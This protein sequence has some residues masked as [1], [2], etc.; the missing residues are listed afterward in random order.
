M[1]TA[2]TF[3]STGFSV[4]AKLVT[5][6]ALACLTGWAAWLGLRE[7]LE[8]AERT[9]AAMFFALAA[10][11]AALSA[12]T[13]GSLS[14]HRAQARSLQA[15]TERM[16][17]FHVVM[18]Q[19]NRL[20]LRRPEPA[21]L[22]SEVCEVCVAAGHTEL[23]VID[24]VGG[25]T[26]TRVAAAFAAPP[27]NGNAISP[28]KIHD[29]PALRQH[30]MQLAVESGMPVVSNDVCNDGR[31]LNW[32]ELCLQSNVNALAAIPLKR[33]AEPAGILMLCSSKTEFFVERLVPLLAEMGADLSFAL[34]NSDREHERRDALTDTARSHQLFQTLF[35]TAPVP[36]AIVS[37][38]DHKVMKANTLWCL[39]AGV[40]PHALLESSFEGPACGLDLADRKSFYERLNAIQSV[41]G[42]QTHFTSSSGERHD[43]LVHAHRVDYLGEKSFLVAATDVSELK[44]AQVADTARAVADDANRAKTDFLARMSHELRTPLNAMLGFAQLLSSD[45]HPEL[46]PTQSEQVRLM[47]KA[48]WHLLSLVDD[49]MDISGIE[50]GRVQV[51]CAPHDI[52]V[53]L[54]EAIA[55]CQPL[56]RTKRVHLHKRVPFDPEV[57]AMIDPGRLRQVLF[58]LLSNACKYNRQGGDVR[59]DMR[60]VGR[61]VVLEVTDNGIGMTAEQMTHLFE[62]FNRLGRHEQ[63]T[64]GTGI[65]LTLSRHL[66]ELMK[67]R[68]EVESS[69]AS[70]TRVRVVLPACELLPRKTRAASSLPRSKLKS[71]SSSVLYIEDNE[72]D[73]TVVEQMML[74]C[75]GVTLMQAENGTDGLAFALLKQPDLILLGMQLPD[76]S[77]FD[78]LAALRAEPRTRGL[79]VVALS[80]SVM[81]EDVERAMAL[82]ALDY[83]TKPLEMDALLEGVTAILQLRPAEVDGAKGADDE[84]TEQPLPHRGAKWARR[85]SVPADSQVLAQ[86][87]DW[88]DAL[89][90]RAR[91]VHLP[92]KFPRIA[93]EVARLWRDTAELDLYFKD[94]EFST[95][96]DR[97][98]FPPI[99]KEE[100]LAMHLHSLRTRHALPP[101]RAHQ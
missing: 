43:V 62:P 30:L 71:G 52:S 98:G 47:T 13:W 60:S 44:A 14:R 90:A 23:A 58:N 76:M 67:G 80:A 75:K 74:R 88:L 66:V 72:V 101:S 25:K 2:T 38:A 35:A 78:V 18:S 51:D 26:T 3:P 15:T 68:L 86:T 69:T 94:K 54:E 89:P 79:R 93:N 17:D 24:M 81:P 65:G 84:P 20:I 21:E 49:V 64:E 57:G 97:T 36:M 8:A 34:D 5:A 91:P 59:V 27:A 39:L 96:G 100:L 11:G 9:G 7:P 70:G 42:M 50:S 45:T 40:A 12:M 33:G 48:G 32:R 6:S 55:L 4:G 56:A 19:T 82:G 63:A 87:S 92:V 61:E 16:S 73:R 85:P 83:W 1:L 99:I 10:L 31:F 37:L 41:I 53:A 95:R 28:T 46:S 29:A 22:F 77:G